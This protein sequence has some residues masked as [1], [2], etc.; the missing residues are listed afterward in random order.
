[1]K[2]IVKITAFLLIIAVLWINISLKFRPDEMHPVYYEPKNTLDV[3]MVG[4]SGWYTF[5]SPMVAYEYTGITSFD[6]AQGGMPADCLEYC[7]R[8]IVRFQNPKVIA[9]D[10]RTFLYREDKTVLENEDGG[11]YIKEFRTASDTMPYGLNRMRMLYS[12]REYLEDGLSSYL[13][14]LF[15]HDRWKEVLAE[16]GERLFAKPDRDF[17]KGFDLHSDIEA[18]ETPPDVSGVTDAEALSADTE[19]VLRSLCE[20]CEEQDFMTVFVAM[21]TA[22]HDERQ[23]KQYNYMRQVIGEYGHIDFL[24]TNDDVDKMGLDFANDF[25]D[26]T[27]ANYLGTIKFTSYLEEY[28]VSR[29]GLSD[30]RGR[31]GYEHWQEDWLMW[32]QMLENIG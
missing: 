23:Q 28:L 29:Y 1:M 25:Y 4:S 21:P 11:E 19:A 26:P 6:Y 13:D 20:Y 14:L 3:I 10:A 2:K 16:G 24:N 17:T 32:H 15:Y 18:F 8:E 5:W 22:N 9:I 27:H 12:M 7:I 31:A 30:R